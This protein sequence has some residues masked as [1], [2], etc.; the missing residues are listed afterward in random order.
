MYNIPSPALLY[1]CWRT[2][3][4]CSLDCNNCCSLQQ[5]LQFLRDRPA[6]S[7]GSVFAELRLQK[8][9]E[10]LVTG[11]SRRDVDKWNHLSVAAQLAIDIV[12]AGE[13]FRHFERQ[14]R[15]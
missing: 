9:A 15:R 3:S 12:V 7:V 1:C 8:A 6:D 11:F 13:D 5:Q 10:L 2:R 4:R 14:I